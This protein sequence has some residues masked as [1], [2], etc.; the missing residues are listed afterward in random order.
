[1]VLA[2][3]YQLVVNL[4]DQQNVQYRE[5]AALGRY[6]LLFIADRVQEPVSRVQH[7]VLVNRAAHIQLLESVN[8]EHLR[9]QT[10]IQI[11]SIDDHKYIFKTLVPKDQDLVHRLLVKVQVILFEDVVDVDALSLPDQVLQ[12]F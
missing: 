5:F 3:G 1:M 4:Q 8:F 6:S 12:L 7:I 9:A 2:R 10:F 11:L